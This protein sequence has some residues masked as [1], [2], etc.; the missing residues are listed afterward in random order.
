MEEQWKRMCFVCQCF[1][2]VCAESA[3]KFPEGPRVVGYPGSG[4]ILG[5]TGVHSG[6]NCDDYGEETERIM[7][8]CK[9]ASLR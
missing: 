9:L 8:G 1:L 5:K 7:S 2:V 4:E 3:A 6:G